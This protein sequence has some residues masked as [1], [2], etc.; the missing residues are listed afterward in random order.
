MKLSETRNRP[1]RLSQ[2]VQ[3]T[4]VTIPTA[5]VVTEGRRSLSALLMAIT[6]VDIRLCMDANPE[7]GESL[8]ISMALPGSDEPVQAHGIVHWTEMRGRSHE[9]GVFMTEPC[10]DLSQTFSEDGRRQYE[11]YRCR[12][13]GQIRR[14]NGELHSRATVVNYCYNGI[15]LRSDSPV[16]VDE[17]FTFHWIQRGLSRQVSA[18]ALWQIEQDGGYLVGAQLPTGCGLEIAGIET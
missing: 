7:V 1:T 16:P 2:R 15:S 13:Q 18:V 17:P 9:V 11:R 8:L 14:T 6:E 10:L 3:E 12:I 5:T 4:N